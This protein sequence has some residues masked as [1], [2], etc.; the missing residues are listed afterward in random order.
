MQRALLRFSSLN[1]FAL[2]RS[3]VHILQVT[4]SLLSILV[5]GQ[6]SQTTSQTLPPSV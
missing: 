2:F 6:T 5:P 1:L 4:R 3:I